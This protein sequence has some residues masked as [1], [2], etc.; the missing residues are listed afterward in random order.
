MQFIIIA[1]DGPGMLDRRMAVR[2]R[3]LENLGTIRGKVLCAGGLLDDAGRMMGSAL[4]LD[5]ESRADL[6]AYLADEPY[7][8]EGVWERVEVT[9]MNVVLLD[10]GKIGK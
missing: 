3:H 6:D 2:A 9:P 1:H 7:I 8:L 10:G 4:V 5:V